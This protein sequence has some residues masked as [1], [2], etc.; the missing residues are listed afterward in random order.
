LL[1]D[2]LDSARAAEIVKDYLKQ[3]EDISHLAIVGLYV[4]TTFDA[5]NNRQTYVHMVGRTRNHPAHFYY[6]VGPC[7]S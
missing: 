2:E 6:R 3:L 1:Q 4:E 5:L 7:R